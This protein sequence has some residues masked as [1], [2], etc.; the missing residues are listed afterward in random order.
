MKNRSWIL[1]RPQVLAACLGLVAGWFAP[2]NAL[3]GLT[4]ELRMYRNNQGYIYQFYTPLSTNALAPAAA[5]G[6][7]TINSPQWP[8]SG[9]TRRF[10]L[11]ADGINTTFGEEHWTYHDFDTVMQQITNGTWTI[12]FTNATTTNHYT[13]TVSAPTITSNMLPA[14]LI[15]FPEDGA[16]VSTNRP[17]FTFQGPTGWLVTGGAYV[18]NSDWSFFQSI[19]LEPWETDWTISTPIPNGADY[20]FSVS[21]VTNYST[22]LFVA[23]APLSTNVSHE[24][25][26]GWVS[27]STL[28]TGGSVSF[29]VTNAVSPSGAH[30]LVAHYAFDDSGD[31]GHDSSGNDNYMNGGSSW[32]LGQD[33]QFTAEAAAGGGAVEFFGDSSI[34]P[35]DSTRTNWNRTLAGSF[36]VS[37]WVKTTASR[38]ND[39]DSAIFGATI[40]WAYNDAGNTNDTIPLAITGSK[41]AFT[42]RGENS[43]AFGN[44]HSTTSVTDDNYHLIT[45]TRDQASGEKKIYVD[46]IFEASE[47]GTTNPLNGNDYYLSLGGTTYSSYVGLLDDVQLYSG[48]LSASEV[49]ALYVTPG[50][51]APDVSGNGLVAHYD[52]D[53][54][55]VLAAD[56]SGSGNNID[57]AGNFGGSGPFIGLDTI[58]GAGSMSFDGGS[59]LTACSNLLATIARDFS[60]S[61]WVKTTQ[62]AG[63]SG[64]M[65]YWGAVIVS[66]DIPTG[67]A[68]DAVPLALT[69]GFVAFNTGDGSSDQTLHSTA[70]VNDDNWHHLVVTRNQTTGEKQI[71]ID[72]A[73][74]NS[75]FGTTVLLNGPQLLTLGAK[76]DANDP[77]PASPDSNGS[78]GY[79]GLLDDVQMYSR[80]LR[81]DEVAYL[82]NHPGATLTTTVTTPYPVEVSLTFGI[83]RQ[84][85]PYNGEIYG[86]DVHFNSVNPEPTTT[87]SVHSPHGYFR[88]ET[89]PGGS[90]SSGPILQSLDEALN[91]FTNGLWT[92]Y[93]NQGSPTQQVYSFQIAISGLDTTLLAPVTVFLPTNGAVNLPQN[94]AFHWVGPTNYS[95]LQVGLFSGPVVYPPITTTNWPSAP[96]LN[97]GPD[98]FYVGYTS[99]NFSGVTFT[100]PVDASAHPIQTWS[101]TLDVATLAFV[102]FVVGA[103]APLPVQL[104][105]QT[106]AGGNIQFSFTTL[107][108]RPHTIQS[109][110][111]LTVGTWQDVTNFIGDGSLRQFSFPVTNP[112]I[113]FFRVSTQ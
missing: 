70:T 6:T 105:N 102:N 89:Y 28:E 63:N 44:L 74:D 23:T 47:T 13:F 71:Y 97:Y 30:T 58:A 38:G 61:L 75:E 109:R 91:E 32:G 64:D 86:G 25:I 57:Y 46:G 92:I 72:G 82:F 15:T 21:Y 62:W 87:N 18:W 77:D 98:T 2:A 49:A 33:H 12:L 34:T 36:S 111:N 85:D 113:M 112:P 50:S 69:G 26:A 104:T 53:E 1:S 107:A 110:T 83:H 35:G 14:T 39:Y 88:T 42:T 24:P 67:G 3:A 48:V 52:F 55:E 101:A 29:A 103:P 65:A 27:T 31:L 5:L 40:F 51:T 20:T 41:A 19:G 45:V 79:E 73:L 56:V 17:R 108:G 95:T 59:Y 94:P 80:V 78:N 100:T 60:I 93:I 68:G 99:N 11:T 43:G 84:Q 8:A 54:S 81:S 66:A 106:W 7:Y 22:P 96:T 10:E 9:S 4:F 76:T 37:A 16:L 90:S